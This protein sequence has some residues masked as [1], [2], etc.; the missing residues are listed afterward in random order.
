MDTNA[1]NENDIA[2]DSPQLTE[3]GF[4][5]SEIEWL[6]AIEFDTVAS[7]PTQRVVHKKTEDQLAQ[8]MV[9]IQTMTNSTIEGRTKLGMRLLDLLPRLVLGPSQLTQ[10][11]LVNEIKRRC[12]LFNKG[13]WSQLWDEM[14]LPIPR[15]AREASREAREASKGYMVDDNLKFARQPGCNK[16]YRLIRLTEPRNAHPS[17][18]LGSTLGHWYGR[19][20]FLA[21]PT[22]NFVVTIGL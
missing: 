4:P 19:T 15:E 16:V 10:N 8:C 12:Q 18:N 7:T 1:W 22:L 11:A 3:D 14:P 20:Y 13:N 6:T 17:G 9:T 21:L 5:P 2:D